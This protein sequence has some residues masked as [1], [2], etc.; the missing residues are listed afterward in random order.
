VV[1]DWRTGVVTTSAEVPD[2]FQFIALRPDGRAAVL[3]YD[4]ALYEVPPGSRARLLAT[5]GGSAAAYAGDALVH[6]PDG[7]LRVIDPSERPRA[8]GVP[9]RSLEGFATEGTQVVWIASGCLLADDV[10][11]PAAAAPGPGPCVRAE[12]QLERDDDEPNPYLT[13]RLPVALRCVAAP[14]A[15][16]GRLRLEIGLRRRTKPI[17]GHVPF[18][19]PAGH[20]RALREAPF[21]LPPCA[22]G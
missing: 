20:T 6:D 15:C 3:T 4:G 21:Q 1:R 2:S 17:S 10:G 22:P 19:I 9:T 18:S 12:L 7:R 8:F 16:R 11:A 13:H 14:G 5:D